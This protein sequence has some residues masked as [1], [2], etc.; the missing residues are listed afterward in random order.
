MNKFY[1]KL[2][3]NSIFIFLIVM[4]STNLYSQEGKDYKYFKFDEE[5]FTIFPK[6]GFNYDYYLVNFGGFEGSVNC[7]L[8]DKGFGWGIPLSLTLE[9]YFDNSMFGELQFGF[10]YGSGLLVQEITFPM[11]D[12]NN[13]NI[14]KI[15]TE[16]Q[17]KMDLSFFEINPSIG[18]NVLTK[19]NYVSRLVGGL[20][21][22][23]PV[24][25]KFTQKEVITS[26]INAVFTNINNIRTKE[27]PLASGTITTANAPIISLDAGIEALT[28]KFGTYKLSFGYTLNNF[29]SDGDWKAFSTRLEI[30]Y[31]IP[32]WKEKE[33]PVKII[34]EPVKPIPVIVEKVE[35]PAPIVNIRNLKVEGKIEVGNELLASVPIVND[36]FFA[37]NSS[38]ISN[39]YLVNEQPKSV[40]TGDAVAL[41]S[42]LLPRIAE[43]MKKNSSANIVLQ[44]STSGEPNE[45]NLTELSKSR[46]EN[47][48]N[49]LISLGVPSSKIKMEYL[50]YPKNPSN[51]EFEAGKLENQRVDIILQNA[52]LQEYVDLQKYADFKGKVTFDAMLLNTDNEKVTIKNNLTSNTLEITKSG[53]YEI[54]LD[55]RLEDNYSNND[56]ELTYTYRDSVQTASEKIDYNKFLTERVD[57]N[58]DNFLAVLRFDYNSSQISN[59][60]KELLR[61]LISKLPEGASI[62]ILGSTDE[63]GTQQRNLILAKERA[64]NTR[65]FIQSI[66]KDK[67]RIEI[68]TNTDKFPED[69]PQGRFLNRSIRIKVKK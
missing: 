3:Y 61:Q 8:F 2:R 39:E 30:G 55:Y 43:I 24:I 11:R 63:L 32:V 26:P 54:P 62:E 66:S 50:T 40:F 48:K 17:I 20:R 13:G 1:T 22:G 51:E 16:N 21:L 45:T 58:L 19:D 31:R 37:T 9:K 69:T 36:V 23:V 28:D 15:T 35:K 34:E 25:K 29:T 10:N 59:E 67:F 5:L 18:Y 38:E 41:H 49:A 12:L 6:I 52:P 64:E 57:L 4:I 33:L 27:R 46:A 53:Q 65:N 68:G 47:V 56:L 7:G 60:N 42:Y 44:S 14:V